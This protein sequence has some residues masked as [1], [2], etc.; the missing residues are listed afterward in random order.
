MLS[1]EN[2]IDRID[3]YLAENGDMHNLLD[4]L[5][6]SKEI[7]NLSEAEYNKVVHHL[8]LEMLDIDKFIKVN[9]LQPITNP[10]IY[11]RNNIPSEDGLLSNKIFGVT[12]DDRSGIF[13]YIDLHGW[14]LDPLCYKTWSRIDKNIKSI[15][16]RDD[17]FS[18]DNKGYIVQDPEGSTGVEFLKKNIDKIKFK[19]STSD[20]VRRDL[21]VKYLDINRH[22]MFINKYPVI[23]PFYRDTNS[24]SNNKKVVGVNEINH[25]YQQLIIIGDSLTA[26]QEYGFDLSGP[27]SLRMQDTLVTIYDWFCGTNN[28]NLQE[29]NSSGLSGKM[30]V[31]RRASMS[32]TSDFAARLVITAPELKVDS[33]KDMKASFEYTELPLSAAIACFEPFIQFNVR[34]FFENEFVGINTYTTYDKNLVRHEYTPKDPLILFSDDRIKKEMDQYIS[35]YANR[36]IPITMKV[37][38]NDKDYYM[39][40]TGRY[41]EY[42]KGNPASHDIPE[43]IY[44]RPLTWLDVLYQAAVEATKDKMILITR[45]PVDTRTNEIATKCIITSTKETE[46]MYIGNTYYKY[47]PKIRKD[48]IGMNTSN[49][50]ID[51][52]N[53]SNLYLEGLGGDYDG[54]TICVRGVFTDEANE[55]LKNFVKEKKN[56]I[57]LGCKNIRNAGKDTIQSLYSITKVLP[58]DES[59][60][61]NPTFK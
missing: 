47:Y 28:A 39:T 57:G 37:E 20:S 43:Q 42:N 11:T 49:M 31:I 44:A 30:G 33:P 54:D 18:L 9:G 24:G 41:E 27:T 48:Q 5:D 35:G 55:E 40:F 3:K 16:A 23:P 6:N 14:Y 21:K 26:T 53:M 25:L 60:L 46:P 1:T 45:Y 32:K 8:S 2:I 13:A 59:K 17:T 4:T 34:R 38:E 7:Q 58:E 10:V 19:D 29:T 15:V 22:K 36:I 12:M 51:T 50:F 61:S 52:M 56:F